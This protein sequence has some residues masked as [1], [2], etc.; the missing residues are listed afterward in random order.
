MNCEST[1]RDSAIA[2][3]LDVQTHLA[4][5]R[6]SQLLGHKDSSQLSSSK[7]ARD[8]LISIYSDDGVATATVATDLCSTRKTSHAY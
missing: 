2:S 3:F 6:Y 4:R 8:S 1:H 7:Y 5:L